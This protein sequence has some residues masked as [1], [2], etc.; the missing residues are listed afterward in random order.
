MIA[1]HQSVISNFGNPSLTFQ[2]RNLA[3]NIPSI[4]SAISVF[5]GLI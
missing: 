1:D 2:L 4:N 5:F 3:G